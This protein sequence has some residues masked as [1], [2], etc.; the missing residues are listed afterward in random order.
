MPPNE[1]MPPGQ[2]AGTFGAMAAAAS[3]D[4]AAVD[5]NDI[6][7]GLDSWDVT[8]DGGQDAA[9]LYAQV[10]EAMQGGGF[11]ASSDNDGWMLLSEAGVPDSTWDTGQGRGGGGG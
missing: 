4:N 8:G 9:A 11:V 3:Q 2:M 5:L 10:T 7:Q 1:G 6:F